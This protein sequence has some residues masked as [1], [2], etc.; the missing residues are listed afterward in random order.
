M[1]RQRATFGKLQRERDKQAK[2]QAKRDRR[3]QPDT[4]TE[5][6][7]DGPPVPP[8]AALPPGSSGESAADLLELIARLHRQ[9]ENHEI[10]FDE[11]DERKAE[12]LRRLPVD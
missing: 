5:G 10:G 1:S 11:Y 9:F 6:A 12:L 8:G 4:E 3:H 2:A 7:H